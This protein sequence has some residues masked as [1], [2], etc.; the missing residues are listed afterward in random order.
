LGATWEPDLLVCDETD[1][2]CMIAAERLGIPYASV[3]VL[4]AGSFGGHALIAE[5]LGELRAEHGLPSDPDLEMLSRYLVL[6]PFPSR[7]R[8][9]AFPLPATAH[10]I[11]PALPDAPTGRTVPSWLASRGERP[12][13]YFTLGTA[14]N[15]ESG[16]LFAR[17]VEGLRDL[18]ITL[19]VT[20]GREIDPAELGAQPTNVHIERYI[21]QSLLLPHCDLVI[22]HGG[23]GSVIGALSHGLPTVLIPLGADQPSNAARCEALGVARVFDAIDLTPEGVRE[24]VAGMLTDPTYRAN[25]QRIRDEIAALPGPEH[26]VELLDRLVAERRPVIMT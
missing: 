5:P 3:L 16:D 25:A 22:S 8:D 6:A 4:I 24:A 10:P 19:V 14:F 26:A 15:V 1:F 17:V 13:V 20:V 12:T 11:R 23:S 2:G 21:P 18:P 7:F 9:P